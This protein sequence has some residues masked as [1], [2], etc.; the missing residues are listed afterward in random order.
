M[1]LNFHQISTI[2]NDSVKQAWGEAALSTIN[3][4]NI[5]ALGDKVMSSKLDT[6]LWLNALTNR[7]GNTVIG[8]RPYEGDKYDLVVKPME[9]GSTLQKVVIVPPKSI[10]SLAYPPNTEDGSQLNFGPISKPEV[11]QYLFESITNRMY[12]MTFENDQLYTAFTNADT[13]G[14][15]ISGIYIALETA[16]AAGKEATKTLAV[17]NFIAEKIK[18]EQDPNISGIHAVNLLTGYN[19]TVTT[20]ITADDALKDAG[21]L[22]FWAYETE[23]YKERLGKITEIYNTQDIPRHTSPDR[24]KFYVLSD[25]AAA[26]TAYLEA[27]TYHNE[28]VKLPGYKRILYWQGLGENAT[29][30]EVSTVDLNVSSDGTKITQSGILGV[31]FDEEA[32]GV[33]FHYDKAES[34]YNPAQRLTQ[35]YRD[36]QEGYFNDLSENGIVFYI[37][38]ET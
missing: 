31:M 14:M 18:A 11:K 10:D 24:L 1:A 37:A 4:E 38:D 23:R 28:L 25:A 8:I 16:V 7:I 19:A 32:V 2:V 13:M 20:P 33:M 22:K 27:D 15:F 5:V 26:A 35:N 30:D 17:A 29:F 36:I 34:F 9:F 3:M 21:F 6:E 12:L